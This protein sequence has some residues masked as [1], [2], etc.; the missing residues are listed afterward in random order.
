MRKFLLLAS[1]I[2][3][4]LGS[5]QSIYYPLPDT[6]AVWVH[7]TACEKYIAI[8]GDSTLG[9]TVYKKC[10]SVNSLTQ[11]LSTYSLMGLLRQDIPN[12]KVYAVI[13]GMNNERLLYD[14]NL[15]LND[16]T[17]V[18][19]LDWAKTFLPNGYKLK[20]E[21]KDSILINGNYRKRLKL[22][23]MDIVPFYFHEVWVEGV[24]SIF[25]LLNSGSGAGFVI[26]DGCNPV[27]YSL[28]QNNN[29]IYTFSSTNFPYSPADCTINIF[30][31]SKPNNIKITPNP[32]SDQIIIEN[33]NEKSLTSIKI[34]NSASE[35]VF[36]KEIFDNRKT[37][38]VKISDYPKGI[39]ILKLIDEDLKT[40]TQKLIV[41]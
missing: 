37:L 16:T 27:L 35:S 13:P 8:K 7:N 4:F 22:K 26:L 41:E 40:F 33:S 20:V 12:K 21:Q 36:S 32:A 31:K 29:L 15:N 18:F 34:L 6:N 39:Y 11:T 28:T 3:S 1:L 9:T 14:F 25:G 24:G 23:C 38:S 10:Y 17:R 5:S 19:P 30:E 2:I